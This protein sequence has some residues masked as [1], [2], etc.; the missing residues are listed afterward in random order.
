[1]SVTTRPS[2]LLCLLPKAVICPVHQPHPPRFSIDLDNRC[3]EVQALRVRY[4]RRKRRIIRL[5]RWQTYLL[6]YC[7]AALEYERYYVRHEI[8][9]VNT[10]NEK[11]RYHFRM[12]NYQDF[13]RLR[14]ALQ[15]P[16][17]VIDENRVVVSRSL[18][19]AVLLKRLA[20]PNILIEHPRKHVKKFQSICTPDGIIENMYGPCAG[21][22]HDGSR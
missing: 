6:L 1:M 16:E 11:M 15:S 13:C 8:D 21:R 20:F 17:V 5:L 2:S 19:L 18:A 22:R 9:L 14:D 4:A 12:E 10:P 3:A 7:H